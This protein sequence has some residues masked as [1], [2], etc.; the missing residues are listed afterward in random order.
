MLHDWHHQGAIPRRGKVLSVV[1]MMTS[2][3]ILL[4]TTDLPTWLLG[5]VA[6]V[7]VAVGL[8]VVSRPAPIRG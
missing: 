1:G 3:A 7:F 8:Y 2:Y 6:I 5:L 4:A